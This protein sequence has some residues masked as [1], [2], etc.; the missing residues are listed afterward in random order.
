MTML[1]WMTR[2]EPDDDLHT[3]ADEVARSLAG[4]EVF[5]GR[6]FVRT[7]VLLPS[8]AAIVVAIEPEA[9]GRFRISD[10]GQVQVILVM[11]G[12]AQRS[13]FGIDGRF[14]FTD[15]GM[16]QDVEP[17]R[18]SGHESIFNSVV[19]HLD[20]VPCAGGPAV[21]ITLLGRPDARV[22]SGGTPRHSTAG[23]VADHSDISTSVLLAGSTTR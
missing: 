19:D 20:E 22:A 12:M 13:G 11:L 5:G 17:F 8:G 7:P 14:S 9:G 15:I 1:G 21:Q 4:A 16:T 23:G 3:I 2:A 6:A 10:L 18:E